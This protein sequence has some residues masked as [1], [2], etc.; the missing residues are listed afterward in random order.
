M[1]PA[2]SA[3]ESPTIRT[4]LQSVQPESGLVGCPGSPACA[5]ASKNLLSPRMCGKSAVRR[6]PSGS[7]LLQTR[8]S[9][10]MA[11]PG[12]HL[13]SQGALYTQPV[14]FRVPSASLCHCRYVER[15]LRPRS[16]V[17]PAIPI[18]PAVPWLRDALG[19][20]PVLF[21]RNELPAFRR[22]GFRPSDSLQRR[23]PPATQHFATPTL[24][25]GVQ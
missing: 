22:L 19:R 11:R 9:R 13:R 25:R 16:L 18:R 14:V 23:S 8:S 3:I 17:I 5:C 2:A 12:L 20:A 24:P 4:S 6:C 10:S 7:V 15:F 21:R 1:E